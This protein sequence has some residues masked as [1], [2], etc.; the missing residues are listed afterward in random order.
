MSKSQK[1]T[2][3]HFQK[4][5]ECFLVRK[6]TN[7]EHNVFNWL[8]AVMREIFARSNARNFCIVNGHRERSQGNISDQRWNWVPVSE[9]AQ[10]STYRVQKPLY[11]TARFCSFVCARDLFLIFQQVMHG[12]VYL[13]SWTPLPCVWWSLFEVWLT[14]TVYLSMTVHL[15]LEILLQRTISG[16]IN[17]VASAWHWVKPLTPKQ[18]T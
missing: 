2:F 6:N 5:S 17:S 3:P 14:N 16:Q 9:L 1:P 18:I 12:G 8:H 10:V 7:S 4:S 15:T 11:L 13:T